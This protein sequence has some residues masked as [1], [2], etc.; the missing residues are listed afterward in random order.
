M[1]QPGMLRQN[2]AGLPDVT[3]RCA[4]AEPCWVAP[5]YNQVCWGKTVLGYPMLQPGMLRQNSAE[6]PDV[7]TGYPEAKQ[8]WFTIV[9]CECQPIRIAYS[10]VNYLL[11]TKSQLKSFIQAAAGMLRQ[12]SAELPDVTTRYAEAKQCWVTRC[13]NQV[14]WG[15]T[16]LSYPML[17]P[18]MLR[19]NSAELPDVTTRYAEAKQC[20]VTRCYNQVFWGKTMSS[21]PRT[22]VGLFQQN[23]TPYVTQACLTHYNK[24]KKETNCPPDRRERNTPH[25]SIFFFST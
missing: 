9:K 2:S 24:K 1:L 11:T 23:Q 15:K 20:W 21:H 14:C 17:Q 19:Q 12:N 7:T 25:A 18:G 5:C 3:T 16:V 8:C 13:Y 4:L 10:R 6:L 22:P